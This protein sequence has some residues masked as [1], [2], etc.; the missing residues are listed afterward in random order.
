MAAMLWMKALPSDASLNAKER[1]AGPTWVKKARR[2]VNLSL[3]ASVVPAA[4][5]IGKGPVDWWKE[6]TRSIEEDEYRDKR[7]QTMIRRK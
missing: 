4:R 3:S 6:R 1:K 7:P 2:M 5:E